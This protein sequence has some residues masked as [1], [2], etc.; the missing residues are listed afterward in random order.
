[1]IS[2]YEAMTTFALKS[3]NNKLIDIIRDVLF[4]NII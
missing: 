2:L 4:G 1:M 3:V